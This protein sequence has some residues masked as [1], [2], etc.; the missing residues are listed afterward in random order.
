[1]H[2]EAG[3]GS[4]IIGDRVLTLSLGSKRDI[5]QQ[6]FAVAQH[7]YHKEMSALT[8]YIFRER[9]FVLPHLIALSNFPARDPAGFGKMRIVMKYSPSK[10]RA[11]TRPTP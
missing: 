7:E 2:R 1:M 5:I 9:D 6:H 11:I 4:W 3:A 10:G 8:Q